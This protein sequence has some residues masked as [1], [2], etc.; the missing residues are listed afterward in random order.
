MRLNCYLWKQAYGFHLEITISLEPARF[1]PTTFWSWS[2]SGA[3]WATMTRFLLPLCMVKNIYDTCINTTN[4]QKL[5]CLLCQSYCLFFSQIFWQHFYELLSYL[6]RVMLRVQ[7]P[8]FFLVF[9]HK[10]KSKQAM[11]LQ[12]TAE[13]G[14]L[15]GL[16]VLLG[17]FNFTSLYLTKNYAKEDSFFKRWLS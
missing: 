9:W 7:V 16:I 15:F 3:I 11:I 14:L 6:Y 17:P 13:K 1:E 12:G 2:E 5:S 10:G 8:T 4:Y